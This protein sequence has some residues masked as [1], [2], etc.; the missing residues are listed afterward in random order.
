MSTA[1]ERVA[2]RVQPDDLNRAAATAASRPGP[3]EC[4][5]GFTLVELMIVVLV[6]GVL[7]A[8]AV[9]TSLGARTR[10]N[11]RVAQADL[12]SGVAT[13]WALAADHPDGRFASGTTVSAASVAGALNDAEQTIAWYVAGGS[14]DTDA[15]AVD[16]RPDGRAVLLYK[17]SRSGEY[18][19]VAVLDTGAV[20]YCRGADLTDVSGF[21]SDFGADG[22]P[23]SGC[24]AGAW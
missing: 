22:R 12:R 10:A 21:P 7:I 20:Y 24:S 2:C 15:I 23:R 5:G 6:L 1:T 8:I 17:P 13:A 14:V 18:F 16:T 9:P 3:V 11:D 19:G 4:E